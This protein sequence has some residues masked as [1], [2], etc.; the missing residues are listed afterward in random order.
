M[1]ILEDLDTNKSRFRVNMNLKESKN[2]I[3][4]LNSGSRS[5]NYS[6]ILINDIKLTSSFL[7]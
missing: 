7:F 2:I 3:D 4:A 5:S 6:D 1:D